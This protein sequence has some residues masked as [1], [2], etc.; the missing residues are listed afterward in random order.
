MRYIHYIPLIVPF[1]IGPLI[2]YF[3]V[4]K[5]N[6]EINKPSYKKEK[7]THPKKSSI[8]INFLYFILYDFWKKLFWEFSPIL[9]LILCFFWLES[10]INENWSYKHIMRIL[11][12]ILLAFYMGYKIIRS[13]F[14]K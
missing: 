8:F 14:K 4:Q 13:Y 6:K 5:N 1:I 9:L 10:A 12:Y 3:F 11:V 2:V 7:K